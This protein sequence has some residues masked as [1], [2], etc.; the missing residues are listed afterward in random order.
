MSLFRIALPNVDAR[1]AGLTEL[2]VS[3]DTPSPKISV[4]AQPPHTG[5]IDVNWQSS[6][7]TFPY[8]TSKMI[9]SFPHGYN[10]VPSVL[11]VFK[12]DNG[13]VKITGVGGLSIGSIGQIVFE[14]DAKNVNLL[15]LSFDFGGPLTPVP[16]FSLQFRFYVFAERGRE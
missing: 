11:G 2:A 3:S 7:L 9:Y 13:S 16:P 15:Y 4:K 14:S 6:N 1:E 10:Y 5:I 8:L 12:F